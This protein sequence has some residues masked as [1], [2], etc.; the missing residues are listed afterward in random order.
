[1]IGAEH[2]DEAPGHGAGMRRLAAAAQLRRPPARAAASGRRRRRSSSATSSTRRKSAPPSP[3][4][5]CS[6]RC[7]L[8]H[9]ARTLSSA[10]A[11][12]VVGPAE[13][14]QRDEHVGAGIVGGH[15]V[16]AS[17]R[18][19]A[20]A[21]AGARCKYGPEACLRAVERG[22]IERMDR[23]LVPAARDNAR[24]PRAG[25]AVQSRDNGC[26]PERRDIRAGWT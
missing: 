2:V 21:A 6:V 20:A 11:G 17:P 1:M 9:S 3:T 26:D 15:A 7:R 24:R 19:C 16:R 4:G 12:L 18:R 10:I 5:R 23:H 22:R 25:G 14:A 13:I 8:E